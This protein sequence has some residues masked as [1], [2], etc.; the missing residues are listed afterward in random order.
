MDHVV[1]SHFSRTS[2]DMLRCMI[3]RYGDITQTL[4]E[5]D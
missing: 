3:R 5:Y 4:E 1:V 2:L